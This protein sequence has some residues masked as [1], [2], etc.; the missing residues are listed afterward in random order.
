MT[1]RS[2]AAVSDT[3]AI[4]PPVEQGAAIPRII[5]QTFPIK[6]L[7]P[8]LAANAERLRRDNPGWDYRLYDDADIEALI[9]VQ[10]GHDMLSL[11]RRIEP[12]YGA[13]R[14]DL[15]RYLLMYREGG[16]YLDIKSSS[17]RP[18]ETLRDLGTGFLLARWDNGP[19][20]RHPNWGLH[21]ELE[22]LG[23]GEFQQWHIVCV[24]GHPFLAAVLDR[25]LDNIVSY[26][27]WVNGVGR[28]GVIR[29]TGPIAYTLAIAPLIDRH[30]CTVF[31][32]EREMGLEY[33]IVPGTSH[34]QLFRK[35]YINNTA[36]VVRMRG[37][38]RP[39]A[40][41]YSLGKRARGLLGRAKAG[42]RPPD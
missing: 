39:L 37:L 24:P 34:K 42:L 33:S 30:D 3:P 36:S 32:N 6:T 38:R 28:D 27:P 35:H 29:L 19:G 5:H 15:F 18:L 40:A 2:K 8:A 21:P 25:V 4:L 13:A 1:M 41:A 31:N 12:S 11:Y 7:P 23:A 26:R 16:V 17:N 20:G 9:H 22:H 10:F 14:A